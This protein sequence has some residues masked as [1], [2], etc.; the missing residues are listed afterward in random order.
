MIRDRLEAGAL[1]VERTATVVC[2]S[3]AHMAGIGSH[4]CKSCGST[5]LAERHVPQLTARRPAGAPVLG[6]NDVHGRRLAH[7]AG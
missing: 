4:R 7:Q 3:C 1:S 6:P 5:E 2:S